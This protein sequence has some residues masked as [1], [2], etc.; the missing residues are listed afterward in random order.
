[1]FAD[2]DQVIDTDYET[3]VSF[4]GCSEF[5]EELNEDGMLKENIE[6]FEKEA[7]EKGE[8]KPEYD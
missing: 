7:I 6:T 4:Y 5:F 8:P 3:Y 1:M 2:Q